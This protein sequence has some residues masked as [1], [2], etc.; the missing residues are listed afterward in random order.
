MARKRIQRDSTPTQ[1]R[2]KV[3][4]GGTV[5]GVESPK[6]GDVITVADEYTAARYLLHGLAQPVWEAEL[7]EPYTPWGKARKARRAMSCS[8][9]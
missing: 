5:H 9:H 1:L 6:R 4:I 2:L 8:A 7:G 3:S